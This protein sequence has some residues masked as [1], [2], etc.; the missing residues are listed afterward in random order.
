MILIKKGEYEYLPPGESADKNN[1][2]IQFVLRNS[3]I[4]SDKLHTFTYTGTYTHTFLQIDK[5]IHVL[6]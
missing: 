5:R 6:Y 4:V 2:V 3:E 1:F